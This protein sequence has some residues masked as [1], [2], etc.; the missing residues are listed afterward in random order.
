MQQILSQAPRKCL[1]LPREPIHRPFCY[2]DTKDIPMT[3]LQFLDR[4]IVKPLRAMHEARRTYLELM[5]LDNRQLADIGLRRSEIERAFTCLD[6][7]AWA[8]APRSSTTTAAVNSNDRA[9]R[10]A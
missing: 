10:A 6:T 8:S 9:P 1:F 4:A 7:L 2:E 3:V 5:A